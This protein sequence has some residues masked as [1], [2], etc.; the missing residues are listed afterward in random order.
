MARIRIEGLDDLQNALK[1]NATLEDV[2]KV[3]RHHGSQMNRKM[4]QN[5]D[6]KGHW[7][8][9]KGNGKVFKKATGTT[10]R[11]IHLEM[12][13]GGLTAECGPTTEYAPYVEHGTRFMSAQPF[14]K[15]AYDEQKELFKSDMQK[16][17]R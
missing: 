15:P 8:W 14:V 3:V 7:A 17:V 2:K 1:Q 10:K 6:F 4:H 12:K 13:D 9:E 5:A 11:S 16:L